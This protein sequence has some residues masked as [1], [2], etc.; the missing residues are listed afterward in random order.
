MKQR[1]INC[2]IGFVKVKP[3]KSDSTKCHEDMIRLTVFCKDALEMQSIKAMIAVQV[4][5]KSSQVDEKG[6]VIF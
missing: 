2:S 4:V 6:K 1:E 3:E 5:G